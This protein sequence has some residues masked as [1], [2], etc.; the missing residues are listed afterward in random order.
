VNDD[1]LA[2][3]Q[4]FRVVA[5]DQADGGNERQEQLPRSAPEAISFMG[6]VEPGTLR[7]A[8]ARV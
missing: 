5:D 3:A 4:Q 6:R 2:V 8:A 7:I 1:I